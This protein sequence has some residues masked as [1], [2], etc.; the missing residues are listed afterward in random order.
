MELKEILIGHCRKYPG[1]QPVDLIKLVYQNEFGCG[2]LL[3][4]EADSLARLIDEWDSVAPSRGDACDEIGNGLCRLH[5][6]AAKANG[7]SPPTLNR[8]FVHTANTHSGTVPGFESKLALLSE[9][10]AG[11][12]LPFERGELARALAQYRRDGYPAVSHSGVYRRFYA[13]AYRVV[14]KAYCDYLPLF[15]RADFLLREKQNP[16]I[17]IDGNAA[18][19]KSSLADLVSTV[20]DCNIVRMDHF[21]LPRHKRTARRF[22]EAGGNVDYERFHD[23][24][25]AGLRGEREF[26]YRVFDCGKM[27]F[28]GEIRVNPKKMTVVEGAYSLHPHFGDPYDLKVFLCADPETQKRRILDRNGAEMLKKFVGLWI[29]MEN[30]Y[31]RALRIPD[32]CDLKFGE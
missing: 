26:A 17:A 30:A 23:E 6:S 9:L 2:H 12:I 3:E 1:L 4:N 25:V 28:S 13:P 21:F 7:L 22:A 10:C 24:V 15:F 11:R 27:D 20:Y 14:R 29:P 5:L 32:R 16:I 18:A 19:G 8:F 31:F